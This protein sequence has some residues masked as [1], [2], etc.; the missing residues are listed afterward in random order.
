MNLMVLIEG[1][2]LLVISTI[3]LVEG[4]RLV[5]EKDPQALYD[6]LGPDFYILFLGIAMMITAITHVV[7]NYTKPSSLQKVAPDQGMR[8]R[9]VG[10]TVVCAAYICLISLIGYL[11]ATLFFFLLGFKII[12]VKSWATNLVLTFF[13]TAF[14]YIVFVKYCT[15][16]LPKGILP[17]YLGL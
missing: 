13:L 17:K 7:V 8:I 4:I 16:P 15:M 10:I 12:G 1:A 14:Y 5:V 6:P 11:W 3:S 2:V 9:M